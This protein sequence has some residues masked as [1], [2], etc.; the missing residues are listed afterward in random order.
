MRTVFRIIPGADWPNIRAAG[1]MPPSPLD[2]QDGFIHL[3]DAHTVL[4]TAD[5]YYP[6]DTHPMVLEI[7]VATLG[8]ALRRE[9]V[10]SRDAYFPHLYAPELSLGA[11]IATHRLLHVDG[12]Y[13]WGSRTPQP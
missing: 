1:A 9:H 12:S 11:V 13:R 7:D 2:H 3:S 6:P 10:P 5:L 8:S 4:E